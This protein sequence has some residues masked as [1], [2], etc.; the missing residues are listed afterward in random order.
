MCSSKF[1]KL[2]VI[3]HTQSMTCSVDSTYCIKPSNAVTQI[4]FS[5]EIIKSHQKRFF[6]G[7]SNTFLPSVQTPPACCLIWELLL[8]A[9]TSSTCDQLNALSQQA[10]KQQLLLP[11]GVRLRAVPRMSLEQTV[12]RG[13]KAELRRLSMQST[14]SPC[15]PFI[16]QN[17]MLLKKWLTVMPEV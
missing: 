14:C 6:P 2:V 8:R 11:A 17:E 3:F 12:Y 7:R 9:D 13:N 15:S 1:V 5:I 4:S 16:S 10:A